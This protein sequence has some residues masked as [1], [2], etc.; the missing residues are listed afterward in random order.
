M[1]TFRLIS[2][3]RGNDEFVIHLTYRPEELKSERPGDEV[4]AF[5]KAEKKKGKRYE[6]RYRDKD[7]ESVLVDLGDDPYEGQ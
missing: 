3:A 6:V 7:A 1:E 4:V 2:E 5:F